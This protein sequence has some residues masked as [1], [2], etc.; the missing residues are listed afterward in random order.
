MYLKY[1]QQ[2]LLIELYESSSRVRLR[3]TWEI[4]KIHV[5]DKGK[6]IKNTRAR[7][8]LK[9]PLSL[10]VWMCIYVCKGIMPRRVKSRFGLASHRL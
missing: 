4:D 5:Q 3:N 9:R 2:I 1:F 8:L 7:R 10:Y 6:W